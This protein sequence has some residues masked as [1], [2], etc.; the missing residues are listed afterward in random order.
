MN[1]KMFL[2]IGWMFIVGL[3][4]YLLFVVFYLSP[5]V[6][7]YLSNTE[8]Q[9]ARMQYNKI[10]TIINSKSRVFEEEKAK[11][12]FK[13]N[14]RVLLSSVILGKSGFI[15]IFDSSG[16]VVIDPSGEFEA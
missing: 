7:N 12:D 3:L 8:I 6:N 5:K 10:V 11:E 1:N 16:Q 4:A 13:D 14:I 2:K 9:N 15:Y